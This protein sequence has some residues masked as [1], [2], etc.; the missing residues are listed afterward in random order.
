M[1]NPQERV[2]VYFESNVNSA[3]ATK[4]KQLNPADTLLRQQAR[5]A[6]AKAQK[7]HHKLYT[8][9]VT[10]EEARQGSD[11]MECLLREAHAKSYP[12]LVRVTPGRAEEAEALRT[13]LKWTSPRLVNDSL[14]AVLASSSGASVLLTADRD[15]TGRAVDIMLF[16]RGLGRKDL[17]VLHPQEYCTGHFNNPRRS[18]P[19]TSW[20]REMDR[21]RTRMAHAGY[22][23]P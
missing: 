14:H 3:L 21:I 18:H 23:Q 19:I 22:G 5:A 6:F 11:P 16:F 2:Y 10:V 15:L 1:R 4:R 9:K 7:L 17:L 12:P 13:A 8:G 20:E